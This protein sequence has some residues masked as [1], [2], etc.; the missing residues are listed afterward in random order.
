MIG[1]LGVQLREQHPYVVG[2]DADG[3]YVL[4]YPC[5]ACGHLTLPV[6]RE[7]GATLVELGVPA[8]YPCPV[9]GA[10]TQHVNTGVAAYLER[11][12]EQ[13]RAWLERGWVSLR[14]GALREPW[15]D[16]APWPEGERRPAERVRR[17]RVP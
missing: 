1:L 12:V 5:S 11:R 9:C 14:F 10:L 2:V 7:D 6:E 15:P 16:E 3:P 13:R 8:S 17:V 4:R